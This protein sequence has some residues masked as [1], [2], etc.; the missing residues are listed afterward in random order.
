VKP[1]VVADP[2]ETQEAEPSVTEA[3]ILG[4]VVNGVVNSSTRALCFLFT[5]ENLS[6]VVGAGPKINPTLW[7]TLSKSESF[8]T[9]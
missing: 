5:D 9:S 3:V 7:L 8:F 2:I 6:L 1:V 4:V